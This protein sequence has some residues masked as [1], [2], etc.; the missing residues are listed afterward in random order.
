MWAPEV[1]ASFMDGLGIQTAILSLPNDVDSSL[2]EPAR[3]GFARQIDTLA[4]QAVVE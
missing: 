4:V 3:H 1:S 2:P